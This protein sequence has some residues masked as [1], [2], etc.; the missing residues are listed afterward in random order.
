MKLAGMTSSP[1]SR[2][3]PPRSVAICHTINRLAL[4]TAS[5]ILVP[6]QVTGRNDAV[7]RR[8]IKQHRIGLLPWANA[9]RWHFSARR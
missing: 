1:K 4:T 9:C 3:P 2:I 8:L 7:G 6:V 5:D